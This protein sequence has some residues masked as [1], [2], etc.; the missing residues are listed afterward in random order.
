M[1][2]WKKEV[3]LVDRLL[4]HRSKRWAS[5][6]TDHW[7]CGPPGTLI[8]NNDKNNNN[9]DDNNNNNN[10]NDKKSNKKNKNKWKRKIKV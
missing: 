2:L 6:G 8:I 5:R 9:K 4:K 10:N 7:L 1:G 3:V